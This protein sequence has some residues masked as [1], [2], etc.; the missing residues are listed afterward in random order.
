MPKRW[1]EPRKQSSPARWAAGCHD[2]GAEISFTG[3]TSSVQAWVWHNEHFCPEEPRGDLAYLTLPSLDMTGE[4]LLRWAKGNPSV[5]A[6]WVLEHLKSATP[7]M[8]DEP[9][10]ETKTTPCG[11]QEAL[12]SSPGWSSEGNAV[13][14]SSENTPIYLEAIRDGWRLIREGCLG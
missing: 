7:A 14:R 10:V 5:S 8:G 6:K 9:V 3:E 4:Q 12:A 1:L 2:C 13:S 11:R